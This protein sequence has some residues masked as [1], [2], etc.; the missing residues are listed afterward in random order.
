MERLAYIVR[1]YTE[2]FIDKCNETYFAILNIHMSLHCTQYTVLF[3][4]YLSDE[5]S[6]LFIERVVAAYGNPVAGESGAGRAPLLFRG[7]LSTAQRVVGLFYARV[8][9][10]QIGC[11]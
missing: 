4:S 2:Y 8:A 1:H 9:H 3:A 11:L 6:E 7:H 10:G 5:G